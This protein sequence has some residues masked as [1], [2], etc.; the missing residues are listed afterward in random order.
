MARGY[1]WANNGHPN[2]V[3]LYL[4]TAGYAVLRNT[5]VAPAIARR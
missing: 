2:S 3:P 4:S 5:Y 1:N